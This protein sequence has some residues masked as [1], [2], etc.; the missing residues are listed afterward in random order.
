VSVRSL[1]GLFVFVMLAPAGAHAAD[2]ELC[3][4]SYLDAQRARKRGALSQAKEHAL[5]CLR[6]CSESAQPDCAAWLEEIERS[7][8]SVIVVPQRGGVDVPDAVITVDGRRIE[9]RARAVELDPG[10]HSVDVTAGARRVTHEIVVREGEKQRRIVIA[11]AEERAPSSS[12]A[13]PPSDAAAPAYIPWPSWLFGGLGIAGA[14][15][16][17]GFAAYGASEEAALE[18]CSPR[19]FPESVDDVQRSYVIADVALVTSVVAAGA[20]VAAYFVANAGRSGS[21]R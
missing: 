15:T 1:L 10:T 21:P 2:K 4:T 3:G 17:A 6:E 5:T 13:R 8:P 16:F 7:M 12:S 20:A 11:L 18:G 9:D 19:C 14:L